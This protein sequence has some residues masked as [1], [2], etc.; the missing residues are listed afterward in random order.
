MS[1]SCPKCHSPAILPNKPLTQEHI[2]RASDAARF[3]QT[4]GDRRWSVLAGLGALGMQGINAL[5]KDC[6]CGACGHTFDL[7]GD[8]AASV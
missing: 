7:E 2:A 5:Y 3:L 8:Q 1:L 4:F 6:R